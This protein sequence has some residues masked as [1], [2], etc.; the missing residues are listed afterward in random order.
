MLAFMKEKGEFELYDLFYQQAESLGDALINVQKEA[1]KKTT[2]KVV[3]HKSFYYEEFCNVK[4]EIDDPIL[5]QFYTDTI[6]KVLN[7]EF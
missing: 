7:H 1:D 4:D 3:F 5:L 2:K 6:V